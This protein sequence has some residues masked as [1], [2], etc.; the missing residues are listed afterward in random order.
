LGLAAL[1]GQ[2]EPT[3][4]ANGEP[5]PTANAHR[6]SLA[7]L[8]NQ[9]AASVTCPAALPGQPRFVDKGDG[10]ICDSATGLMWEKKLDCTDPANPRCAANTYTWSATAPFTEPN[11]SLYTS[12]LDKLNDRKPSTPVPAACFAAHC[13]WRL[14]TLGELRSLLDPAS[15]A[16]KASACL[17]PIFGPVDSPMYAWSSESNVTLTQF[18]WVANLAIGSTGFSSKNVP[19]LA[20]AVRGYR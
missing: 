2:A 3:R 20:R 11:G 1:A 18:A 12:F 6:L 8:E 19:L 4:A 7:D 17:D 9:I 14:P 5:A 15:A 13:D 16:C 10:T